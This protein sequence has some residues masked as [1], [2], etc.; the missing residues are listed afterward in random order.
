[1]HSF[2]PKRMARGH[3]YVNKQKGRSKERG[4]RASVVAW[5]RALPQ[6]HVLQTYLDTFRG[7]GEEARNEPGDMQGFARTLAR[8][9]SSASQDPTISHY[10]LHADGAGRDVWKLYQ[11]EEHAHKRARDSPPD[12]V[13]DK[14]GSE[15]G[16]E[17]PP[18]PKH[19]NGAS[20]QSGASGQ[21]RSERR[22]AHV[23][24]E[25]AVSQEAARNDED[26]EQRKDEEERKN[27]EAAVAAE[28]RR[29][30]AAAAVKSSFVATAFRLPGPKKEKYLER[31]RRAEKERRKEK[32]KGMEGE[33]KKTGKRYKF[34]NKSFK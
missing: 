21:V 34:K 10:L 18:Q 6:G 31:K 28:K 25:I 27:E 23:Q 17:T 30:E 1:M 13:V 22:D 3:S 9:W 2:W 4:Y 29:M 12:E 15:N 16:S 14:N 24:A 7:C 33:G 11:Y 8:A 20:G 19:K 26:A 32:T 5:L